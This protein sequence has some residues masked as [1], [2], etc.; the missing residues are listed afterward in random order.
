[1]NDLAQQKY[2]AEIKDQFRLHNGKLL[3][4][5]TREELENTVIYLWHSQQHLARDMERYQRTLGC[6]FTHDGLLI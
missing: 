6:T 4:D 5:L 1:M 2:I 3:K